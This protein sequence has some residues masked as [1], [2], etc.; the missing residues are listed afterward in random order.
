MAVVG[1][2]L[3]QTS[4]PDQ[5]FQAGFRAQGRILIAQR[6]KPAQQMGVT[7]QLGELVHVGE[8]RVEISEKAAGYHSI[9]VHGVRAKGSGEDAEVSVKNL[10]QGE[11]AVAHGISGGDKRTR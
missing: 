2:V 5:I 7:T 11:G 4:E 9:V 1:Q 6:A 8:S 10:L 3:Q